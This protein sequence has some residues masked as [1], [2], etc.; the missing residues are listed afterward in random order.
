MPN[1]CVGTCKIFVTGIP[2]RWRPDAE[3]Y[4]HFMLRM[5][6]IFFYAFQGHCNYFREK[7]HGANNVKFYQTFC[8]RAWLR[9]SVMEDVSW[10]QLSFELPISLAKCK[11]NLL[12][13]FTHDYLG[14][15]KFGTHSGPNS[16][17]IIGCYCPGFP[18]WCLVWFWCVCINMSGTG[19][20]ACKYRPSGAKNYWLCVALYAINISCVNMPRGS[21]R[22][23]L[24]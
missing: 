24:Q 1:C 6:F 11:I 5:I 4:W 3:K 18:E 10:T 20:L 21:H 17:I 19:W 23:K 7:G 9:A 15:W 22:Q 8:F 2:W 13:I 16:F 14:P 12:N